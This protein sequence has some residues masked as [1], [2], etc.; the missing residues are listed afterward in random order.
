MVALQLAQENTQDASA[1]VERSMP[2]T[3]FSIPAIRVGALV[4]VLSSA[5][6]LTSQ[7]AATPAAVS[8][9]PDARRGTSLAVLVHPV[10]LAHT[11]QMLPVDRHGRVRNAGDAAAQTE[12]ALRHVELALNETGATLDDV[13]KLNISVADSKRVPEVESVLARRFT[14]KLK[15]AVTFVGGEMPLSDVLVAMDAVAMAPSLRGASVKRF[16]SKT[17]PGDP[18]IAHVAILPPHGAVYLAGDAARGELAEATRQ[19]MEKLHATLRH[20]QL[21]WS[22]VVHLKAF[23]R[24]MSDIAIAQDVMKS[25]FDGQLTPPISYVEWISVLPIEIELIA[26]PRAGGGAVPVLEFITPPGI[27]PSP[28][29]SKVSRINHGRRLYI[30]GLFGVGDG[31]G[32]AQILE[33]FD[34]LGE[35]LTQAGSDFN[36][37]AKA[38]YYVSDGEANRKLNELRPRFYDPHRP[39]AASKALVKDVGRPG[40]TV[41]LDMIAV[42]P[43]D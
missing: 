43:G 36:H 1:P 8:I 25:F 22:D 27:K 17:L 32:E 31:D 28:V 34:R 39:P 3:P 4:L 5:G 24:P 30:S 35:L 41:S 37:L 12:Q 2:K 26:A 23:L 19:T 16:R 10:P 21:D 11:A 18:S 6:C 7:P 15:P 33:I 40:K 20:L 42:A 9:S 38:T 14:G 29:Y 13:V